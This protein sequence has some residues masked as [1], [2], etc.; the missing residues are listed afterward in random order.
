LSA[1]T[2]AGERG[3]IA[4]GKGHQVTH[5]LRHKPIGLPLCPTPQRTLLVSMVVPLV[6]VS[7]VTVPVTLWASAVVVMAPVATMPI[8]M[9]PGVAPL[10]FIVMALLP[11]TT[12]PVAMAIVVP[13]PIPAR[14]NDNGGGWFN[15]HRWR[16]SVDRLGRVHDTRDTNIDTD[17]NV[18]ECGSGYTDAEAGGQC[19]CEPACA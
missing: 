9:V 6:A 19:Y 16:R 10:P 1:C 5:T 3:R 12:P 15:V 11:L 4:A 17:I 13:V 7:V 18:R 2:F 8:I 14:T